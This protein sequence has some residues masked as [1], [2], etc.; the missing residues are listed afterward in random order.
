M[1]QISENFDLDSFMKENGICKKIVETPKGTV[2]ITAFTDSVDPIWEG[3]GV[4]VD[5]Y[6]ET[7]KANAEKEFIKNAWTHFTVS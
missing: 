4:D 6:F 7:A 5:L 2:T 3:I 1:S